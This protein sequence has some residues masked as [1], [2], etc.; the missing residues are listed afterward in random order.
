VHRPRAPGAAHFQELFAG[1]DKNVA[2][3]D[4]LRLKD[5]QQDP[6]AKKL[7][8]MWPKTQKPIPATSTW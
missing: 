3:F 6:K 5:G 8:D 4:E 7:L 2:D 1:C